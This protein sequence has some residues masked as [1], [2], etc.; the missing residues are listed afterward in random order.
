V[1]VSLLHPLR[2]AIKTRA[3]GAKEVGGA[4]FNG[5]IPSRIIIEVSI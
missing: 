2:S 5:I 3:I 1:G 4:D